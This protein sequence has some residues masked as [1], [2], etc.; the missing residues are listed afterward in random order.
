MY[1]YAVC[2]WVCVIPARV[3]ECTYM[4]Y[5]FLSRASLRRPPLTNRMHTTQHD[6]LHTLL[7]DVTKPEQ[8]QSAADRVAEENLQGLYAL[9]NNAGACWVLGA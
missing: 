9:V 2:A 3:H 1:V 8:V 7:L 6:G 4:Y 5:L